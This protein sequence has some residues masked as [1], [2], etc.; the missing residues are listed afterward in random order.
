MTNKNYQGLVYPSI[1]IPAPVNNFNELLYALGLNVTVQDLLDDNNKTYSEYRHNPFL[2]KDM[3]KFVNRVFSAIDNKEV[4]SVFGDYDADGITATAVMKRG[5]E[6]LGAAMVHYIAP[7]RDTGYSIQRQ[8]IDEHLADLKSKGLP[9]PSLIITVD[10]GIKSGDEV[11]Y[12]M[13]NY[14]VDIIITDHHLP[15]DPSLLSK[16]ALAIVDPHQVDC[17][18]P[19]PHIS[20]SFV[21]LKCIEALNHTRPF[22]KG[23]IFAMGRNG[24]VNQIKTEEELQDIAVVGTIADVMP[25]IDENRLLARTAIQRFPISANM[26]IRKWTGEIKGK[27]YS[28]VENASD[29]S[30]IGFGIGPRINAANRVGSHTTP[31][32]MLLSDDYKEVEILFNLVEQYNERRKVVATEEKQKAIEAIENLQLYNNAVLIHIDPNIPEGIIGLV[33]GALKEKFQRPAIVLGGYSHGVY[34]GSCRS[35]E[36]VHILNIITEF[37]SYLNGYGGHAGAA[38]FSVSEEYI[39]AFATDFTNYCNSVIDINALDVSKS[40][41]AE[42]TDFSLVNQPFL[43]S[44][45]LLGPFGQGNPQ[46]TFYLEG[47]VASCRIYGKTSGNIVIQIEDDNR[48]IVEFNVRNV[49]KLFNITPDELLQY[50]HI[51]DRV[52]GIG[53]LDISSFQGKELKTVLVEDIVI[54]N[55]ELLNYIRSKEPYII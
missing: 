30:I 15:P 48:N 23:P 38:G 47:T 9:A 40:V 49:L 11:D 1:S 37:A 50:I 13:E 17:S 6:Y 45:N 55:Q 53:V 20:G 33:A 25:V 18:Y 21:A 44:I 43:N 2:M 3:D 54:P 52:W 10:C 35:I 16:R 22:V 36:G 29:T 32:E 5:L 4:I 41:S 14:G 27:T 24:E 42:I 51:G 19:F 46:P 39:E 26:A 8:Y 31:L 34:K 28:L 7:N 12:I